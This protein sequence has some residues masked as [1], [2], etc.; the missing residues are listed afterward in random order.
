MHF[1]PEHE[2]NIEKWREA[3]RASKVT[4]HETSRDPELGGDLRRLLQASEALVAA[5][6]LREAW[7]A[8]PLWRR[9]FR[10]PPPPRSPV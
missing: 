4:F 5:E 3:L 6:T 10:L 9:I 8:Q 2:A 1:S 7:R